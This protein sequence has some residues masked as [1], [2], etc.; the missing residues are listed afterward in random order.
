M[1]ALLVTQCRNWK[2]SLKHSFAIMY[3]PSDDKPWG[4]KTLLMTLR[5]PALYRKVYYLFTLLATKYKNCRSYLHKCWLEIHN[6]CVKSK[7]RPWA[8]A[9]GRWRE[10]ILEFSTGGRRVITRCRRGDLRRCHQE[11]RWSKYHCTV[12]Y[13]LRDLIYRVCPR[14]T[15]CSLP[16][17]QCD[18]RS[19]TR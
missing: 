8:N 6:C 15:K 18:C 17:K 16:W 19:A 10:P 5:E 11:S 12:S 4:P 7:K 14:Y 1:L 3:T 9:H 13:K 2:C